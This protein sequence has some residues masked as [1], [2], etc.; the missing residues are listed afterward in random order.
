MARELRKSVQTARDDDDDD[1]DDD[2]IIG[3]FFYRCTYVLKY[4]RACMCM[5]L[6][7]DVCMLFLLTTSA[8][9]NEKRAERL[10]D[11]FEENQGFIHCSFLSW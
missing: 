4:Q 10:K 1:D 3:I 6:C 7:V 8:K 11:Y 5:N 2:D 9:N